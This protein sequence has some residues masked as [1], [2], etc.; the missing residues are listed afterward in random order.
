MFHVIN[1][2]SLEVG[3][4]S[5]PGHHLEGELGGVGF[6]LVKPVISTSCPSLYF[7]AVHK[8]EKKG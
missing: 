3:F 6:D 8:A 5:L 4:K 7:G 1:E 2:Q